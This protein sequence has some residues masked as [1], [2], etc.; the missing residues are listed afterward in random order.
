MAPST[1]H[2]DAVTLPDLLRLRASG[3]GRGGFRYLGDGDGD[4]E[5]LD[6]T[7]L[8]RRARYL[9]VRLR[10]LADRGDRALLY[11]PPGLD[12][13]VGFFAASI[14]GLVGV[15]VACPRGLPI[16]PEDVAGAAAAIAD[17]A[18]RLVLTTDSVRAALPDGMAG[19]APRWIA[20]DL[21]GIELD[22]L[23][24]IPAIDPLR[25]MISPISNIRRDRPASPRA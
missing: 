17:C 1:D 16:R 21:I 10:D 25:P 6:Y 5:W 13:L 14:A 9:A 20:T 19:P 8:H 18:P 7:A 3:T 11:Y 4:G 23:G 15:P 24:A 2:A 12:F 22:G